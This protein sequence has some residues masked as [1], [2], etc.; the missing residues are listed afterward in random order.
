[1][2]F[3][4]ATTSSRQTGNKNA[5]LRKSLRSFPLIEGSASSYPSKALCPA[6]RKGKVFEPNSFVVMSGGAL[7]MNRR[8]RSGGPDASLDG[9]LDLVW[10]GAH[11]C[12]LGEHREVFFS[13]P[14]VKEV[15]GG[16]FDLYFCSTRCLRRFLS[17]LVDALET[18]MKS[19]SLAT[20]KPSSKAKVKRLKQHK[21]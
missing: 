16:Q 5:G 1:M 4:L 11:D 10:H 21:A 20:R 2:E 12:G 7:L 17:M 3:E 15:R 18:R 19:P 13:M 9:F 14:I 6:C 8:R